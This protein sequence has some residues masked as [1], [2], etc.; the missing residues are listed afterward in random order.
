MANREGK[1]HERLGRK[2][3]N[4]YHRSSE[5]HTEQL[6]ANKLDD[7]Q[8]NEHFQKLQPTKV[9]SRRN[10]IWTYRSLEVK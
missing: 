7:L 6:H 4:W 10:I 1:S 9:E 8:K 3:Y 2:V 5:S